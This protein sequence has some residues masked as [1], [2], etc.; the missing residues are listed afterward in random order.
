MSWSI[1]FTVFV[2]GMIVFPGIVFLGH[3]RR[4]KAKADA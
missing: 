3:L 2:L 1:I 4:T